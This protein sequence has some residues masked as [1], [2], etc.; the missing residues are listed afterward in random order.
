M[1]EVVE[2]KLRYV[3]PQDPTVEAPA[4]FPYYATP[5]MRRWYGG[6]EADPNTRIVFQAMGGRCTTAYAMTQ[7]GAR[8]ALYHLGMRPNNKPVDVYV[9]KIWKF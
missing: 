7:D 2:N 3:I 9:K 4:S 6:P 5:D 8:K 1:S